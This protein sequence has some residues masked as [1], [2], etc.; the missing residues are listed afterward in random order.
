M[1]LTNAAFAN[2]RIDFFRNA[3]SGINL[4]LTRL[5][6]P[7]EPSKQALG[8]DARSGATQFANILLTAQFR[9]SLD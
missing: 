7:G 8:K 9:R 3:P 4:F 2:F 5:A 6:L 1:V